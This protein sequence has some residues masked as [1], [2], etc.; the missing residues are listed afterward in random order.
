M[1]SRSTA[2]PRKGDF[3]C[4]K[5]SKDNRS[6]MKIFVLGGVHGNEKTGIRLVEKLQQEPLKNVTAMLGNP[7][8]VNQNVR[9]IEED[10]NR[11]RT[12]QSGSYET[13]LLVDIDK[14]I[15]DFEPDLIL[16]FHNTTA[17]NNTLLFTCFYPNETQQ[18]LADYFGIRK[19]AFSYSPKNII[20]TNTDISLSIEISNNESISDNIDYW[21]DKI[22]ELAGKDEIEPTSQ[23]IDI[24]EG[25]TQVPNTKKS[26]IDLEKVKNFVPLPDEIKAKLGLA[27]DLYP[28]FKGEKAYIDNLFTVTKRLQ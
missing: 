23:K 18:A 21:Y 6:F 12:S 10:L 26:E 16:D 27:G 1:K 7:E 19:I 25:V 11:T 15:G 17:D 22:K 13:R 3:L 24:Y 2:L 9:Y 4:F 28:I 8:A 14:A 20:S 5:K